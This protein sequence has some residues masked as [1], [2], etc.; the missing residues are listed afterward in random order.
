MRRCKGLVIGLLAVLMAAG[1]M[2]ASAQQEKGKAPD[3]FQ[4][5]DLSKDQ[6]SKLEQLIGER[7]SK[8]T[9]GLQRIQEGRKKLVDLIY[10]K[11]TPEK[12]IDKATDQLAKSERDMLLAE[13]RF[14][15]ELRK[16]LSQEQL[17]TL[18]KGQ[19]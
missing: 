14:N 19:K 11:K 18:L 10:D 4:N 6:R 16:L 3:P 9:T 12:E 5:L 15:K 2:I 7:K 1:P 17:T 13:V 8:L